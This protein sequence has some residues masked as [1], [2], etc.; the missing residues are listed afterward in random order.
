MDTTKEVKRNLER[1]AA[2]HK[3]DVERWN[4][5]YPGREPGHSSKTWKSYSRQRLASE[6][7]RE[8]YEEINWGKR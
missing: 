1:R 8:G 3:E 6:A 5:D 2:E 4:K 7:F